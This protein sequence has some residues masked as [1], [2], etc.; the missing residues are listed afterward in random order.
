MA[1]VLL[2]AWFVR[3]AGPSEVW[4]GLRSIGWGF[5]PIIA[6]TGLRFALRA[7]ALSLCVEPAARPP[8]RTAFAAVLAGDALGN[9]TP[10]GLIASEP[11]KA[12]LIR[13]TGPLAPAVAAVAIETLIYTLSV[14]AM[15]A[16]TTIALLVSFR[17]SDDMRHAAWGAVAAIV[18]FF[19]ATA[20]LVW[21]QPA[22]VRRSLSAI[23]PAGSRTQSLVEKL[24]GLEQQILTFSTR[25]REV[26]VPVAA[27]EI[28]FHVLGVF[29]IYLTVWMILGAAPPLLTAFILEGA[30]RVVQVVFKPVPLRTGVDEITTGDLYADAGL[31]PHARNDDGDRA[32]GADGLLGAGGNDASRPARDHSVLTI[33]VIR[34]I[35][36]YTSRRPSIA[37][38]MVTSSA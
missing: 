16:A 12:A 21:R 8:F 33:R 1:G 11:A 30:N 31:R 26:L 29:E 36:V 5:I 35:R 32:E 20:V 37:L 9:V 14:G 13:G 27:A 22:I 18:S 10:L 17:L 28:G 15:I 24:H 2:F 4:N 6:V 25:R 34:A 7:W 19:A 38:C 23:L 3:R